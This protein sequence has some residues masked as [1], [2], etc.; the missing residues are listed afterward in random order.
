MRLMISKSSKNRKSREEAS[1]FDKFNRSFVQL[2][3]MENSEEDTEEP[4]SVLIKKSSKFM[5]LFTYHK[6]KGEK[7]I[8]NTGIF[9]FY[10]FC[11]DSYTV[12]SRSVLPAVDQSMHRNKNCPIEHSPLRCSVE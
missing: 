2:T 7:L 11:C 12:K 1:A 9:S 4:S 3:K 8:I 6:R 5:S 10:S